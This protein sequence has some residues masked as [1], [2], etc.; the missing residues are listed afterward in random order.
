MIPSFTA[1]LSSVVGKVTVGVV[2]ATTSVGAAAAAGAQIPF[3]PQDRPPVEE[4][5]VVDEPAVGVQPAADEPAAQLPAEATLGEEATDEVDD[6]A[7]GDPADPTHGEI[8]STFTQT[9]DLEGCEKG[10]ATA[11]VARGD[12]VPGEDGTVAEDELAPYLEKC[13]RGDVEEPE[14]EEPETDAEEPSDRHGAV[15]SNFAHET[16]LKGCERGQAV[17]AVARGDVVPGEDG[18][19]AADDLAPYLEKCRGDV[20][21]ESDDPDGEEIESDSAGPPAHAD[22]PDKPDKPGKPDHAG[23]PAGKGPNG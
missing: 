17:A 22:K 15:V 11:A 9:T 12:V 19:V 2:V 18:T 8:V 14:T 1:L 6:A 13:R 20:Q 21:P 16:E 4:S 23:P 10:Q 3:V 5:T 7:E